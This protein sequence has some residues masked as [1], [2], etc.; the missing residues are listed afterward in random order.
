M[1]GFHC[2]QHRHANADGTPIAPKVTIVFEGERE[3]EP[4]LIEAPATK[5]IN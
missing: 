5:A 1:I 4:K 3:G 2:K